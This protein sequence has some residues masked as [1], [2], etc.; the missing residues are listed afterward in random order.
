[1]LITKG[2]KGVVLD[3]PSVVAYDTHDNS[4]IATGHEAYSMIGR[5][6]EFIKIIK[7]LENGVV[8]NSDITR[9][10]I[11]GFMEKVTKGQLLRPRIIICIPSFITEVESRAVVDIAIS[12]GSR[13]IHLLEEPV[14]AVMGAGIDV[15]KSLGTLVIDIGGG[16]TDI[17]IISLNGIVDAISIKTAGNTIDNSL[18]RY[19][20]NRHKLS[21]GELT[22]ENIKKNFMNVF[23]SSLEKNILVKG[24]NMY[25]N[26][27][28][29]ILVSEAELFLAV[30]GDILEIINSLKTLLERINPNLIDN[31][32]KNGIIMTG[33]GSLLRGL[34]KLLSKHINVDCHIAENPIECVARGTSIAFKN[35]DKLL[36][37]F[38][39]IKIKHI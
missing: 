32:C 37:G 28:D 31:I 5:T 29:S 25:T 24:V 15:S 21:I 6:P 27:P 34:D 38:E 2:R 18:I 8:S 17:A 22:A 12:T 26:L 13:N 9:Q 4:I 7:P 33:G 30:Q 35:M 14:S 1:I 23:N 20:S 16:T 10:L 11:N 39:H 3:E 36:D 19:M